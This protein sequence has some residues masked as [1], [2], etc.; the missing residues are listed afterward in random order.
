MKWILEILFTSKLIL[1][2]FIRFFQ[3][4]FRSLAQGILCL[5]RFPRNR[6]LKESLWKPFYRVTRMSCSNC[7]GTSQHNSRSTQRHFL[8]ITSDCLSTLFL[9]RVKWTLKSSSQ[10][11]SLMYSR[12]SRENPTLIKPVIDFSL[13]TSMR[14]MNFQD[15]DWVNL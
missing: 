5:S 8:D 3:G 15:V 2:E 6:L 1:E 10:V 7:Y 11:P 14:S 9:Q 13:F 12:L 4:N